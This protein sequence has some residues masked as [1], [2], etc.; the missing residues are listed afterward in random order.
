[1]QWDAGGMS[2]EDR[3]S[4]RARVRILAGQAREQAA[5]SLHVPGCSRTL[6]AEADV[7]DPGAFP[8][9]SARQ[10][11]ACTTPWIARDSL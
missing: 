10:S 2:W 6:Q 3:M 11:V 8:A 4:A 1:M 7:Q 9:S 5:L